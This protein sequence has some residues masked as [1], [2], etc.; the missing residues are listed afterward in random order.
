MCSSVSCTSCHVRNKMVSCTGLNPPA[1]KRSQYAHTHTPCTYTYSASIEVPQKSAHWG[2]TL[3]V[4]G[5]GGWM[6]IQVFPNLTTKECPLTTATRFWERDEATSM[7]TKQ[8]WWSILRSFFRYA[9]HLC[10]LLKT[11]QVRSI[12]LAKL[13][14]GWA[15]IWVNL[16]EI[17]PKVGSGCSFK[18]GVFCRTTVCTLVF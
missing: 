2:C 15:L 7:Y 8:L 17:Q 4:C 6:F 5:G 16:Q 3:Q 10:V 13:T 12:S 1:S 9:W 14:P 11:P 18:G